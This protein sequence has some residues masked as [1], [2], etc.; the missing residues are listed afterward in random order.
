MQLRQLALSLLLAGTALQSHA[1]GRLADI[2][3]VDRDSGAVLPVHYHQGEYWVAGNPGSR[4]AITYFNRVGERL[5]AVMSV[6]G[7]NVLS[8]ETAGF[9][10]S[11]YVLSG[12]QRY[13][14]NGWR[15]SDSEVAAFAFAAANAS[16]AAR[17]G[18]AD[19][20]GVIG[21]ALFREQRA[22]PQVQLP[23]P[24]IRQRESRGWRREDE[25]VGS[26][27][28]PKRESG[29]ADQLSERS[30]NLPAES[31]AAR[32]RVESLGK[33]LAPAAPATRLGTAHGQRETSW[34]SRTQ[35]ERAQS[36]PDE[37]IQIRYDSRDN[38]IASGVIRV[39]VPRQHMPRIDPFP[40]SEQ[41]T[42]VPDPPPLRH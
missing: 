40:A 26:S 5:L 18:R 37:I 29:M 15:K 31:D 36:Q 22:E 42:Y 23:D 19:N 27:S 12:L 17:T 1:V 14:V 21:V 25:R 11:G 35:F 8:G 32:G 13:Q 16:Y 20:I 9:N 30:S 41:A 4:Y 28:S 2:T 34:V 3:I 10:Q 24:A 6:D 38:L 33:A 7:V 39:P